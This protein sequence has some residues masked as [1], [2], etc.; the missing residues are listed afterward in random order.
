MI[1]KYKNREC[2]FTGQITV[3]SYRELGEKEG[4]HVFPVCYNDAIGRDYKSCNLKKKIMA[5]GN[6]SSS[7]GGIGFVGLLTIAFTVLK[8]TGVIGWS[9]W[10]VISP[11]WISAIVVLLILLLVVLW[12]RIRFKF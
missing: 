2:K 12:G 6:N 8:L 4:F 5:N 1:C 11:I 9:W 10:W 3:V 7:G